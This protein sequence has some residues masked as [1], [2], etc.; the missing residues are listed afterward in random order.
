MNLINAK[1]HLEPSGRSS[2]ARHLQPAETEANTMPRAPRGSHKL[3]HAS[4]LHRGTRKTIYAVLAAVCVMTTATANATEPMPKSLQ[5]LVT[6]IDTSTE[7]LTANLDSRSEGNERMMNKMPAA[8]RKRQLD[9]SDGGDSLADLSGLPD[10]SP[11]YTDD[12]GTNNVNL[13]NSQSYIRRS[14]KKRVGV[15]DRIDTWDLSGKGCDYEEEVNKALEKDKAESEAEK[16]NLK[17]QTLAREALI[18][19]KSA[20]STIATYTAATAALGIASYAT[21]RAAIRNRDATSK[22]EKYID[23]AEAGGGGGGG[24]TDINV[25]EFFD[26]LEA[27]ITLKCTDTGLFKCTAAQKLGLALLR[28]DM[29]EKIPKDCSGSIDQD[30]YQGNNIAVKNMGLV[31]GKV[32]VEVLITHKYREDGKNKSKSVRMQTDT[33]GYSKA[34]LAQYGRYIDQVKNAIDYP[35]ICNN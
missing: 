22:L 5:L 7:A 3:P 10:T 18:T 31:F 21:T 29:I 20:A 8:C 34:V 28:D 17:A 11:P 15:M 35:D 33:N 25:P 2:D 1:P 24:G 30:D 9:S 13:K 19:W 23:N 12:V 32:G 4:A 14:A 27:N 26:K 16:R 6:D